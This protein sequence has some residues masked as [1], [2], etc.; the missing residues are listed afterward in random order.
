[1]GIGTLRCVV[2]DVDD[3][4]VAEGFWSEVPG[5]PVIPSVCPGRYS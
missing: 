1:M 3:L 4:A 2:V 5:L